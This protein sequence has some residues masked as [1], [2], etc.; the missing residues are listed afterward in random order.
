MATFE[1]FNS[2]LIFFDRILTGFGI[3]KRLIFYPTHLQ[4]FLLLLYGVVYLSYNALCLVGR[5]EYN[6]WGILNLTI[7]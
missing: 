7:L 2:F 4:G 3:R 1:P 6:E 5:V